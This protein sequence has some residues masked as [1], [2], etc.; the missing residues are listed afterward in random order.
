MNTEELYTECPRA[1]SS[2]LITLLRPTTITIYTARFLSSSLSVKQWDVRADKCPAVYSILLTLVTINTFQLHHCQYLPK[3]L[4]TIILW[5]LQYR[6]ELFIKTQRA[7]TAMLPMSNSEKHTAL[8]KSRAL[9]APWE[10]PAHEDMKYYWCTEWCCQVVSTPAS[11]SGG[12][13]SNLSSETDYPI[14][15]LS[16]FSSVFFFQINS[17]IVGLT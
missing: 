10:E 9:F 12:P 13:G 16:W 17:R 8:T 1:L 14:W 5:C 3:E 2:I 4:T 7:C 6:Y 15:G 11:Y